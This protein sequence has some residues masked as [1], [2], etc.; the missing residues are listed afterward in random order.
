MFMLNFHDFLW[1]FCDN[2]QTVEK[3]WVFAEMFTKM[4][5]CF[6]KFPKPNNLIIDQLIISF[7]SS[8]SSPADRRRSHIF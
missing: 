2:L 7:A 4:W 5:I 1:E 6:M 8:K 3:S